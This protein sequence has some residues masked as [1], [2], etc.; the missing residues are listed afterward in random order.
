[1]LVAKVMKI[2]IPEILEGISSQEGISKKVSITEMIKE[3]FL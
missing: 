1:M 3:Q 2:L